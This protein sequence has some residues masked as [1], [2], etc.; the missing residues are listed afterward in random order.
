MSIV[1]GAEVYFMKQGDPFIRVAMILA[2]IFVIAL[3]ANVAYYLN[4]GLQ[5][6]A[7]LIPLV[8]FFLVFVWMAHQKNKILGLLN[9]SFG[10]NVVKIATAIIGYFELPLTVIL[11]ICFTMLF[12]AYS[13]L[14]VLL[15]YKVFS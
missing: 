13:V 8:T 1:P 6:V 10:T 12:F 15:A 2:L 14:V 7:F 4:W 5:F 9:E 11:A 3:G